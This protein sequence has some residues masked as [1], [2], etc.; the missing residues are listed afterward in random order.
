MW[1]GQEQ[2]PRG[3]FC[4]LTAETD[5]SSD[6]ARGRKTGGR[7]RGTPNKA[8]IERALI[9][10]RTVAGAKLV[11]KKLAKEVLE[12]FMLIFAGMAFSASGARVERIGGRHRHGHCAERVGRR[13]RRAA[14]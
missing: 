2:R 5:S 8:T 7:R 9:A 3:T 14:N 10:A 6:M 13:G 4:S 12:D 1:P 11:G